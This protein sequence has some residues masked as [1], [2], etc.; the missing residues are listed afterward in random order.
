MYFASKLSAYRSVI[1]LI[2]KLLIREGMTVDGRTIAEGIYQI[3]ELLNIDEGLTPAIL[4]HTAA[5][6]KGT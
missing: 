3:H 2:M 4:V 5:M 6:A 1:G